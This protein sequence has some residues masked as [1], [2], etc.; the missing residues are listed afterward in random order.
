MAA[1][2]P[3]PALAAVILAAGAS[4]RMGAPKAHLHY[5]GR[6]FLRRLIELAAAAEC[7]PILVIS[8]AAELAPEQLA[9]A[10]EV[11]H[12]TWPLGQLSS[13]QAGLAALPAAC[14]GA[15]VLTVDRPHLGLA[16]LCALAA[17]H[18]VDPAAIWRPSHRGRRGHPILYPSAL[19]TELRGLAPSEDPRPWLRRMAEAGSCRELPVDD[20]AILENI[21]TPAD[22]ERLL[23]A[24][25]EAH[26]GR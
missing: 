4:S 9:P 5:R 10:L 17:A 2:P 22:L 15:L 21:D 24:R 23:A 3:E 14:T 8:G 16:T 26:S 18:A 20:P 13:L 1:P 25:E 6:T 11:F 12:K 19:F 7:A